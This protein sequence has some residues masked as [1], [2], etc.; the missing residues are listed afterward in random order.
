MLYSNRYNVP[1][2]FVVTSRAYR[3][4]LSVVEER[5]ARLLANLNK[6]SLG[7]VPRIANE[8]QQLILNAE[9][10]REITDELLDAYDSMNVEV[11][12]IRRLRAFDFLKTGARGTI[13]IRSCPIVNDIDAM[14][15]FEYASF[16]NVTGATQ[17]RR[18]VQ[19]CFAAVFT[20]KNIKYRLLND[21][22]FRDV[23]VSVLVQRMIKADK[24]GVLYTTNPDGNMAEAYIEA[25]WGLGRTLEEVYPDKYT[26]DKRNNRILSAQAARQSWGYYGDAQGRIVQQELPMKKITEPKLN[27]H[28]II[29][30]SNLAR[31]LEENYNESFKVEFG[32]VGEEIWVLKVESVHKEEPVMTYTVEE[33]AEQEDEEMIVPS[34]FSESSID[35]KMEEFEERQ[36]EKPKEEYTE[37][38]VE[39][40][41]DTGTLLMPEMSEEEMNKLLERYNDIEDDQETH[42]TVQEETEE[43]ST[44]T[45][46]VPEMPE[47][48][49]NKLMEE[50]DKQFKD[51][52]P[53]T[54]E[55]ETEEFVEEP[56]EG[57]DEEET[58][59]IDEPEE[60][61]EE[62]VEFVPRADEFNEAIEKEELEPGQTLTAEEIIRQASEET[63]E[64]K[65]E[66][67]QEERRE[68][69]KS[70]D[71]RIIDACEVFCQKY[72]HAQDAL[73]AYRDEVLRLY[74]NR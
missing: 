10:P 48:E 58:E 35:E 64:E 52:E 22:D 69:P 37:H 7:A 47:E 55:Q 39:E 62:P 15:N 4:F 45:V 71:M 28:N 36:I 68:E 72:P 44:G 74:R 25:A 70:F 9:M 17:L 21:I 5:I 2:G 20:Q 59:I 51:E 57:E 38:K 66:A 6:E 53:E 61:S 14:K 24:S 63:N 30:L 42:E 18:A 65:T 54:T 34:T 13:A 27:A 40:N 31:E 33:E 23:S 26:I 56:G 43:E 1:A 49:M 29:M 67:K 11:S 12:H 3:I 60:E 46:L 41:R 19:A 16:L 50:Y 32:I 73:K 8:I